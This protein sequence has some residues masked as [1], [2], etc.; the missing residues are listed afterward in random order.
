MDR[1]IEGYRQFR[2]KVWPGERARY[3]TLALGGQTPDTLVVA[4]SDS[5]VDPQTV[6]GARPG[7]LFVVRNVAGLVPPYSPDAGYHGTSAALEFAVR[8]LKVKRIVVLGHAQCGGVKAMLDS[9]PVET[10]DFVDAW[11]AIASPAFRK[12]PKAEQEG[13]ILMHYE[14]EVTRLSLANLRTF[15]WI[16]EAESAGRLRLDGFRF[17][18]RSGMLTQLVGDKFASIP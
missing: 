2:A 11:M 8:V 12:K 13:D 18:I 4:C 6:F 9:A 15:P 3:E 7:E 1:L 10:R 14:S 5:R 16:A 17:D